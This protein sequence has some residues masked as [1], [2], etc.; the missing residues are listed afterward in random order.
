MEASEDAKKYFDQIKQGEFDA[1]SKAFLERVALPQLASDGNRR[2]IERVRRRMRD[3]LL[4][5]KTAEAA[6]LNELIA[7][8]LAERVVHLIGTV[9]ALQR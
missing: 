7:R 5:E 1:S 3:T 9:E 4:N 6:A 2:Q 8:L